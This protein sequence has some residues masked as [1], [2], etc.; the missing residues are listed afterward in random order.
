[1]DSLIGMRFGKTVA[2]SEWYWSKSG[3]SKVKVLDV[4]CD[5]GSDVRP[6]RLSPFLKG[7]V[8]A[9]VCAQKESTR[10]NM[11]SK[12]GEKYHKLAVVGDDLKTVGKR[13]YV[14]VQCDCGSAPF[15]IRYDL[16]AGKTAGTK[17]CGCWYDETRGNTTRTHG[18]AGTP[19]HSVWLGLRQRCN[20]P[21]HLSYDKYGGKGI[22]Y[23]PSWESFEGFYKDMAS[24]YRE[25][26]DL[27]RIDFNGNYCKENCR[28]VERDVGNHNK[29]KDTTSCTSRFKGVYYDKAK[30]TFVARLYRKGE[31][32]LHKYFK[33][34]YQAALAYDNASE[35]HYGDR[36][37]KTQKE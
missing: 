32:L 37:N 3:K 20:N 15:E 34:E 29:G 13:R 26:L 33:D 27:D 36:P 2:V 5:C 35:I 6:V 25:G 23:S 17:S 1:M 11:K 18:M 24:T 19:L 14:T 9:C 8:V 30:K 16:I 22:T 21:N 7:E 10:R 4:K 12:V 28:W 31:K